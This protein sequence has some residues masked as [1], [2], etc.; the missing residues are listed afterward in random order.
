[1]D[2]FL[3]VAP[4]RQC[5]R[6][7]AGTALT[8]AALS[9]GGADVAN[10]QSCRGA[11][12][13]TAPPGTTLCLINQ[14]RRG[15]GLAPLSANT[16][17]ARAAR[18]HAAD[19]VLRGYFSHVSP[20]G[21]TFVDRLRKVGYV[22]S[23]CAWNAGETLAWGT[24]AQATPASRVAAWMNS[25]PHRAILL[26]RAFREAGLGIVAGVPGNRGAGATYVGEFGRRRC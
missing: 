8:V 24:G 3:V 22:R 6:L 4:A 14:E 5:V 20:D 13:A 26:G 11:R 16:T 17:L 21:L 1:V 25:P 19:M 15:R 2:T 18:R 7:A 10:A 9:L 12:S 23:S